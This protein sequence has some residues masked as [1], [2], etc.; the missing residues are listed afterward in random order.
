MDALNEEQRRAADTV[1]EGSS[2][3]ITGPGGVGKSFLLQTLHNVYAASQKTLAITAMTGC[4]A[5]LIGPYAKT[6]HS[7]AGI[8]LGRGNPE[9]IIEAIVKDGKR[10]KRWRQ[11]DCLIID[12]V[13]MLTPALMD[14]LDLVGRRI[15]KI[16]KPFGGLQMVFVGDFYQLPPVS[17]D[18]GPAT[19]TPFAFVS[20]LWPT[21][22]VQLT[23]ILRQKD[24]LFQQILNEARTG[25]LSPESYATL[26]TRK[27]MDWKRQEIKP[28][29]LFTKNNDVNA[30]NENQLAKLPGEEHVFKATTT[31]H[32]RMPAQAVQWAVE[33]LDRDASYEVTLK[34]KVRAQVMLL[35]QP[36]RDDTDKNGK[37]T[38]CPI[39]GLVNGSRGIITEFAHDGYPMV[40]FLNGPQHPVKICP[41]NWD[42]DADKAEEKVSREQIPLRLAY[43]LTIHKAQG[44]SL[45]SALIDVGPSTF[46]YGQAYVALSRVRSLEALFIY[47]IA[48]KAFKAHPAVKAFY[49]GIQEYVPSPVVDD[50]EP[51]EDLATLV[52]RRASEAQKS[53]RDFMPETVVPP[54]ECGKTWTAAA[55]TD[56]NRRIHATSKKHVDFMNGKGCLIQESHTLTNSLSVV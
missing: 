53:I 29:L 1:L 46:E 20:P 37:P 14:L 16:D 39:E 3:F 56:S 30:I 23:Q 28:T 33:K 25:D 11:T 15:R 36:F 4:A 42:S 31:S 22:T 27:T 50:T 12:E 40:K 45:D 2:C 41:T 47:E 51:D 10:K 21:K 9:V 44:A 5:L 17:K 34:L 48:T 19:A 35:K 52:A 7:W 8:G 38:K 49:A 43:A 13:S 54:C 55:F 18:S 26:E 32:P 24:P 6:L